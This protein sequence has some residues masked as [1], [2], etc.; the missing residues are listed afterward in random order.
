MS[1][2]INNMIRVPAHSLYFGSFM[3]KAV[4]EMYVE[5]GD[6][7]KNDKKFMI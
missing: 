4:I 3:K 7:K 6:Y 1:D 2:L 5:F